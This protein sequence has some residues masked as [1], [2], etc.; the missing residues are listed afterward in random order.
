MRNE[1]KKEGRRKLR[2]SKAKAELKA[3]RQE[4]EMLKKKY[5]KVKDAL[6]RING[7][8]QAPP[9]PLFTTLYG[10]LAGG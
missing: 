2:D 7:A 10:R 5:Q 1:K 8:A 4:R 3:R 6:K 9:P